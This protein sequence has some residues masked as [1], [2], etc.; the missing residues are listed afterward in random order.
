MGR[1]RDLERIG[2]Q[3]GGSL[4]VA[5]PQLPV[6]VVEAIAAALATALVRDHQRDMDARL[7]S[8][9]GKS[10]TLAGAPRKLSATSALSFP[11]TT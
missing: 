8:S 3:G 7:S 2:G 5:D 6:D 11:K 4:C 10:V 9:P 1:T